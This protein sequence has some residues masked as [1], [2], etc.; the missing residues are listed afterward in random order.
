MRKRKER[1]GCGE[2]A[3]RILRKSVRMRDLVWIIS[4][5]DSEVIAPKPIF[6]R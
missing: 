6:Q 3:T 4:V 1:S 5:I 2:L